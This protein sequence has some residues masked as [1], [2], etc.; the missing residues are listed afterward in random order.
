MLVT[1]ILFLAFLNIG[2][3]QAGISD[4][5]HLLAEVPSCSHQ[6]ASILATAGCITP[7]LANTLPRCFCLN[8]S[9]QRELAICFEGV[10]S[11]RE[12]AVASSIFHDQ[13]CVG[14]PAQ[15][16]SNE[17]ILNTAI[18]VSVTLGFVVLRIISRRMVTT[19]LDWDDWAVLI[20]TILTAPITAIVIF[21]ANHGFGKHFWDIPTKDIYLIRKLYYVCQL[22]YVLNLA[23][24]KFSI[25]FLYRRVFVG[26]RFLL[27]V[28]ITIIFMALYT[29]AFLM[30]VSF[31]CIPIYSIWTAS[32]P[33]KCIN[34]KALVYT[35][36]ALSI[37]EDLVIMFLP[38]IELKGLNLDKKK[39]VGLTILFASGSLACVTSMVRL[40]YIVNYGNSVDSTWDNVDVVIWSNIET[41]AALICACLVCMRPLWIR[42]LPR[43]FP[44]LVR[45]YRNS[46]T[47]RPVE[48][49]RL[50]ERFV[51]KLPH[52][53]H[54]LKLPDEPQRHDQSEQEVASG[55]AKESTL[56]DGTTSE[57]VVG[58][59]SIEI[60][61]GN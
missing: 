17:I 57:I 28:K 38:V 43:M 16:R 60:Q 42:V 36:A 41:Y 24:A 19:E 31:Q 7:D 4:L 37:V 56:D 29:F 3:T 9:L 13:V 48:S 12:S 54:G 30:V 6:C 21:N 27:I 23:S 26:T 45:K 59:G 53:Q 50:G 52:G 5:P 14:Y 55:S 61:K 20:A 35:G 33:A 22:L 32:T 1:K 46:A 44:S 18:Q 8:N 39:K 15:L 11:D 58:I 25:L 51:A 34:T 10:C 47:P 49:W 2:L 40:K